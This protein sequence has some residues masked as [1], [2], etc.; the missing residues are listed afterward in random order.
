MELLCESRTHP[1]YALD[2]SAKVDRIVKLKEDYRSG[3]LRAAGLNEVLL[4]ARLALLWKRGLLTLFDGTRQLSDSDG[5]KAIANGAKAI[6]AYFAEDILQ[7]GNEVEI[8]EKYGNKKAI[9]AKEALRYMS[10]LPES[11]ALLTRIRELRNKVIHFVIPISKQ[12]AYEAVEV[13]QKNVQDFEQV[14]VKSL[15]PNHNIKPD[16]LPDWEELCAWCG[17]DFLPYQKQQEKQL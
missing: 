4:K 15:S 7:G 6:K 11:L 12:I 13:M 16:V 10:Q 2:E 17:I 1:Q 3:L 8:Q 14:W 5:K 9:K